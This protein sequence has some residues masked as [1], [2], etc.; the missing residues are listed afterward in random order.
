MDVAVELWNNLGELRALAD[1]E[2]AV[3]APLVDGIDAAA[4]HRVPQL[5]S[6]VHD[7]DGLQAIAAHL[8]T[9]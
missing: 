6:D 2:E 8:F 7:L 9:G 5:D 3:I 1:A 4:V